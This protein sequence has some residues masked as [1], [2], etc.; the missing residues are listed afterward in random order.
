MSIDQFYRYAPAGFAVLCR[1]GVTEFPGIL[2]TQDLD[3]YD[4]AS[5]TRHTLRYPYGSVTVAPGDTITAAGDDYRVAGLPAR[6]NRDE[7]LAHLSLIP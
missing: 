2:D 1:L 4:A 6:I 7:M 5:T 3:A